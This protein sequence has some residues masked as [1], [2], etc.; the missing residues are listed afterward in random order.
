MLGKFTS[1]SAHGTLSQA[2]VIQQRQGRRTTLTAAGLSQLSGLGR[3]IPAEQLQ[4]RQLVGQGSYGEVFDV[5]FAEET[6]VPLL[7]KNA[8]RAVS[9]PADALGARCRDPSYT[10]T[11]TLNV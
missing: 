10:K 7:F 9:Q 5:R 11:A 6:L 8:Q 3:Q 4:I 1:C 2:C